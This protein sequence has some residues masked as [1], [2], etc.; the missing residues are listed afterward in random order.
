MGITNAFSSHHCR[1]YGNYNNTNGKS[2]TLTSGDLTSFMYQVARGM[3]Y[4][5]SRGIIHRDLAARNILIADDH[6]CKVADFG[7]ARD[8]VTSKVYERKSEGRL[9]IR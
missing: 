4:L 1:H 2:K 9:P 7:F 3:D 5:T 6:T 8:I